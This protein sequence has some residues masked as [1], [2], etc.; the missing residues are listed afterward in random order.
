VSK[1]HMRIL[2]DEANN[3]R[4]GRWFE[5]KDGM[6]DPTCA[7]LYQWSTKGTK[8]L[9]IWCDGAGENHSH[10]DTLHSSQWKM[11]IAL[12]YTARNTPQQ[13]H[14]A[15]IGIYVICCRGRALMPRANSPK[16]YRYRIFWLATETAC[17][18]DWL[19]VVTIDGVMAMKIKYFADK[20]PAFVKY[21]TGLQLMP[22]ICGMKKGSFFK[23][24]YLPQK[25][26]QKT[27]IETRYNLF[28]VHVLS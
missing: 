1:P 26:A 12:E 3:I 5:T 23:G 14:L 27:S 8:T 4:F 21:L 11:P 22:H 10:E 9:F 16:K 18:L 2:V 24:A 7:T 6:V 19:T 25:L 20:V 28:Q 15:E 17:V 13:N